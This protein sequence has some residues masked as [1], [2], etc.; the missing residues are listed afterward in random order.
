MTSS[1]VVPLA[2]ATL[3]ANPQK[4]PV[5]ISAVSS[6][7]DLAGLGVAPTGDAVVRISFGTLTD[8]RVRIECVEDIFGLPSAT[9]ISPTPNLLGLAADRPAPVPFRKLRQKPLVDGEAGGWRIRDGPGGTQN[10]GGL[11]VVCKAGLRR[12]P[13]REGADAPGQCRLCRVEAMG[14]AQRDTDQR[15][16]LG[17]HCAGDRQRAGSGVGRPRQTGLSRRRIVAI[18]AVN[19]GAGTITVE[20]AFSILF[21]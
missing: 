11:L 2:R 7:A 5:S 4:L 21:R 20:R 17:C 19:L 16:R 12:F 13:Q 6:K 8:G 9:N 3:V 18:K 10:E 15:H 14:F 1:V